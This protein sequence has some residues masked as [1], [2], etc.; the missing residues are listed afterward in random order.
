M[1]RR[2]RESQTGNG[3]ETIRPTM[4]S[5]SSVACCNC[6]WDR[7]ITSAASVK[8]WHTPSSVFPLSSLLVLPPSVTLRLQFK[9]DV[10]P[11]SWAKSL[12][13][14]AS[15]EENCF[16]K[17]SRASEIT[18]EQIKAALSSSQFTTF[19]L[20]FFSSEY[21][22]L[23]YK[24]LLGHIFRLS[25]TF[26]FKFGSFGINLLCLCSLSITLVIS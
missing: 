17:A 11:C 21:L 24:T 16:T 18:Q 25:I 10:M 6:F 23:G 20:F 9:A 15:S 2:D 5:R 1:L 22:W 4:L 13:V 26:D 3:P 19:S 7:L 8:L 14:E 12:P